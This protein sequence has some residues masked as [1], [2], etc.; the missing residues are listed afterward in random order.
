[1]GQGVMAVC[2]IVMVYL[3]LIVK[4]FGLHLLVP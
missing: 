4:V 3:V 1:M 2:K